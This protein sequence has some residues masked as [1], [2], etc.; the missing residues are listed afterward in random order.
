MKHKDIGDRSSFLQSE[1]D[2]IWYKHHLDDE[3]K[4]LHAHRGQP[5]KYPCLVLSRWQRDPGVLGGQ[6]YEHSFMDDPHPIQQV[7]V[8]QGDLI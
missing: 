3:A 7:E 4:H 6:V 8:L 5:D 2:F 1:F